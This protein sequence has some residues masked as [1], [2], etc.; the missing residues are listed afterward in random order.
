[1]LRAPAIVD[2]VNHC[3]QPFDAWLPAGTRAAMEQDRPDSVLDQFPLDGPDDLFALDLV[4]FH[5]LLLDQLIEVL[6]AIAGIIL[7]GATDVVL[8]KILVRVVETTAGQVQTDLI[9]LAD[10][11]GEPVGSLDRLEIA[12]DIYLFQLVDQD[13]GSVAVLRDVPRRLLGFNAIIGTV[14]ELF[15][16]RAGFAAVLLHIRVVAG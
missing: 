12:I 3:R 5:G 15:H 9:I 10:D 1:M 13:D 11:F 14:A 2:A 6:A 16:D 8:I 7:L 4:R